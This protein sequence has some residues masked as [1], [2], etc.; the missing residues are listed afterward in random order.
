MRIKKVR[1]IIGIVISIGLMLSQPMLI[2][3]T[4]KEQTIKGST[5]ITEENLQEFLKDYFPEKMEQYHVP[6]VAVTVVKGEKELCAVSFGMENVETMKPVTCDET[7]FPAASVS[8]LFT[9]TAIM[10]LYEG[11]KLDLDQDIQAYL[12]GITIRNAFEKPITCRELLTHSSGLDEQSELAGSTL[13]RT[14]IES[15]EYYFSKHIPTAIHEPGTVSN[16][17]NM[18]YNLLGYIVEKVSGQTY[19]AYVE[20]HIMKPLAMQNASIRVSSKEYATGYLFEDGDFMEQPLA[21]QYTSG[22]SGVL[23]T[24]KDM[25]RFL[26]MNLQGGTCQNTEILK[27]ET[28]QMMHDKQF[29]NAEVFDGMG[30]GWVRTHFGKVSVLKHEG[31]LPG[32]ATTMMLLPKENIGIYVATNSLS[33]ICFDFEEAFMKYFYG[34]EATEGRRTVQEQAQYQQKDWEKYLGC[35]R[36]YDGIARTNLMRIGILFD[37]TD[38]TIEEDEKQE[39]VLSIYNQKK[40]QEQTTLSYC[41]EGVFNRNDGKGYVV[42]ETNANGNMTAYTQVSHCSYEKIQWYEAKGV[43]L[44]MWF[45][46]PFSGCIC[47]F[48]LRKKIDKK[49]F[50]GMLAGMILSFVSVMA[51]IVLTM[52]MISAYQYEAMKALYVLAMVNV[53]GIVIFF[54][55][56]AIIICQSRK[57][58][59]TIKEWLIIGMMIFI[60]VAWA[61]ELCYF[62]MLGMHFL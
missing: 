3:A 6:G 13:D 33:G 17:S 8:K 7:I 48:F 10:Q 36:T 16:Y 46:M 28:T 31:A 40:E 15:Q 14:K 27:P 41:G 59:Y 2:F 57:K 56:D 54:A 20:D 12:P 34:E 29:A 42:I 47:A 37:T 52:V 4:E 51:I 38:M 61:L 62:Q 23:A 22:S 55:S 43:L 60:H 1:N 9:A 32:Y 30:F 19:E 35:Y 49:T 18:G 11:G 45:V 5:E 21:Y 39:I 24:A 25:E 44:C 50:W 53:S 58:K 26:S